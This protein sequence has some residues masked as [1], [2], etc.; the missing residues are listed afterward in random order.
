M[1]GT[2]RTIDARNQQAFSEGEEHSH[3]GYG[4]GR[5]EWWPWSGNV[6]VGDRPARG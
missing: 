2:E 6:E 5:W 4:A 1:N 3:V